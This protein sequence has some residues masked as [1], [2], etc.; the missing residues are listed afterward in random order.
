MELENLVSAAN[1]YKT[2]V[3][4]IQPFLDAIEKALDKVNSMDSSDKKFRACDEI[5]EIIAKAKSVDDLSPEDQKKVEQF[6][7]RCNKK[8]LQANI[9]GF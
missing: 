5:K 4:F 3:E 9:E 1:R 7:E 2:S 6:R 8:L